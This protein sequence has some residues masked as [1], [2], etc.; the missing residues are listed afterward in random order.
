LKPKLGFQQS[1]KQVKILRAPL[2]SVQLRTN[3][4]RMMNDVQDANAF[5]VRSKINL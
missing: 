5:A 1:Q 2:I 4:S 3:F